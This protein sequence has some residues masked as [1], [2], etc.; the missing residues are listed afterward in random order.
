MLVRPLVPVSGAFLTYT[1]M[2]SFS[3]LSRPLPFL[4]CLLMPLS[5][6]SLSR[7]FSQQSHIPSSLTPIIAQNLPEFCSL[8]LPSSAP[9]SLLPGAPQACPLHYYF[10]ACRRTLSL[11]SHSPALSAF[12]AV[13]RP[14]QENGLSAS[15]PDGVCTGRTV[16]SRHLLILTPS[17]N[18]LIHNTFV[19]PGSQALCWVMGQ[20]L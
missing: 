4:L 13:Y 18:R 16:Y 1:Q 17:I 3:R 8:P 20:M 11:P 7:L 2:P 14:D 15:F 5:L 19:V 9:H 6:C 12:A 10:S